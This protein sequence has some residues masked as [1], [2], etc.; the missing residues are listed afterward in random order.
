MDFPT[1]G[2]AI[3]SAKAAAELLGNAVTLKVE[4]DTLALINEARAK[5]YDIQ[6]DLLKAN[7]TLFELQRQNEALLKKFKPRMTGRSRRHNIG[8]QRQITGRSSLNHSTNHRSTA[9]APSA[10]KIEKG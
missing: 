2:A 8:W 10:L 1:I 6:G 7:E 4:N 5:V 9:S 3:A